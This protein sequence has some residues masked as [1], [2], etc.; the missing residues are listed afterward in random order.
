MNRLPHGAGSFKQV[1][2]DGGFLLAV[3]LKIP[4]L[5]A[6]GQKHLADLPDAAPAQLLA[7][8]ALLPPGGGQIL[9]RIFPSRIRSAQR[10]AGGGFRFRS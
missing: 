6:H 7:Q 1:L 9:V 2:F 4:S 3:G 5:V 10:L 8:P